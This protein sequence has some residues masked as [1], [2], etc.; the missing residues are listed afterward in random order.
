LNRGILCFGILPIAVGAAAIVNHKWRSPISAAE[1]ALRF[2]GLRLMAL[3]FAI[4]VVVAF[5][6]VLPVQVFSAYLF[7]VR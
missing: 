6:I 5:A 4:M 2:I 1:R 3:A 7:L